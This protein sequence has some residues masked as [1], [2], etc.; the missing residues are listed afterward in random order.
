[1]CFVINARSAAFCESSYIASRSAAL[2]S[3][4]AADRRGLIFQSIAILAR[5]RV[6]NKRAVVRARG[7]AK[8]TTCSMSWPSLKLSLAALLQRPSHTRP[9][10]LALEV[11][12]RRRCWSL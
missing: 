12:R 3:A 1:M 2:C 6:V 4:F 9:Q 8:W 10:L 11:S 7:S 5:S